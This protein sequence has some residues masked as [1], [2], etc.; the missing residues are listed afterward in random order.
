MPRDSDREDRPRR[1]HRDRTE[2]QE[3]DRRERQYRSDTERR[4]TKVKG[5]L[6]TDSTGALLPREPISRDDADSEEEQRR[7]GKER[8]ESRR[9]KPG[10]STNTSSQGQTLSISNLQALTNNTRDSG[11]QTFGGAARKGETKERPDRRSEEK[12]RERRTDATKIRRVISE[13]VNEPGR[14]SQ[15]DERRRSSRPVTGESDRDEDR[16]RRRRERVVERDAIIQDDRRRRSRRRDISHHEPK[17]KTHRVGGYDEVDEFSD[18]EGD[19]RLEIPSPVVQKMRLRGGEDEYERKTRRKRRGEDEYDKRGA[20]VVSGPLLEKGAFDAE[21]RSYDTSYATTE[22]T[23]ANARRFEWFHR[24]RHKLKR[25]SE[26]R[27]RKACAT[28]AGS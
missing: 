21:F 5:H 6:S 27:Y 12:K 13:S 24:N 8:R 10:T 18:S 2:G 4:R 14:S 19:R 3:P 28:A 17:R 1:N 15:H 16:R 26:F 7:R 11:W 25:Y 22:G 23:G 20:R 9:E